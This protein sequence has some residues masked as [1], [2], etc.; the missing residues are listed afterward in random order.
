MNIAVLGVL[1]ALGAAPA[2]ETATSTDA[3][4]DDIA[5]REAEMFGT[6]ADDD[7]EVAAREA[8]MFGGES[9]PAP[10]PTSTTARRRRPRRGTLPTD[11][12]SVISGGGRVARTPDRPGRRAR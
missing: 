5:A 4:A 1:V 3:V 6:P 2:T 7:P 8:E 10:T 11:F 9:E 12:G